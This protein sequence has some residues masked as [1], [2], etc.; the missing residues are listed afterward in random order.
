MKG[1]LTGPGGEPG[2]PLWAVWLGKGI[3]RGSWML[4]SMLPMGWVMGQKDPRE[5]G[6]TVPG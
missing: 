6:Q 4:D 5:E 3:K 1:E 2:E